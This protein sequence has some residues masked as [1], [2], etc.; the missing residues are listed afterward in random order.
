[1]SAFAVAQGPSEW[2]ASVMK[3]DK[4]PFT[5]AYFGSIAGTLYATLVVRNYV[6]VVFFAGVQLVALSYYGAANMPYGRAGLKV[7]QTMVSTLCSG[8]FKTC[9][10]CFSILWG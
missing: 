5:A 10:G 6:A 9:K 7:V 1:M 3:R 4:L 8:C 2:F